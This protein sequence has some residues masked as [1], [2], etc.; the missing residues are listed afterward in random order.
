M[1]TQL[2]LLGMISL[3]SITTGN[4]SEPKKPNIILIYVDDLGYGDL[5][6]YG[7]QGIQTP[8]IDRLAKNGLL[9]T[10]AHCSA[11]TCTPSRYSLLTGSYAFRSNVRVLDGGEPA[12]IQPGMG[13]L[14]SMLQAAGYKTAIVGKWHLG[15][16]DGNTDWNRAI[17]PGP[18]EVGFDYS[19][20]I[21]TT[22]DR[23]PCVWVEN[24][25]IVNFDPEDPV[26]VNYRTR[27]GDDPA[28]ISDPELLRYGADTQ[29]NNTIVNGISRIGYMTGGKAAR[30]KD[31]KFPHVM[32]LKA[33]NFIKE[34]KDNP[35]FLYFSFH[36]I[37]VP[38]LPDYPFIG[39]SGMGL[40][41]DAIL[42]TD[43]T[44]GELI[45]SIEEYG[46]T[47]NTLVI[48][49]SDNGPVLDDGYD[50][51][52]VEL[53]GEHQPSGPFRGG[54]YSAFE[55]GTRVPTIVYWPGT[56]KPGKSDA[57][58]GQVDLYASLASLVGI[59]LNKD[60]APDSYNM[61][62]V[63][64]GKSQ[65]GREYL[66]EE[67][68]TLSLRYNKWKYIQ[69]LEGQIP[70]WIDVEKNIE[71]GLSNQPQ[72]YNL[73]NDIAET[74]N[75]A[76]KEKKLVRQLEKELERIILGKNKGK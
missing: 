27:V 25:H 7:A 30:W 71:S 33:R 45:K 23:V 72:L 54:K 39:K 57:L 74:R 59:K 58:A 6:C 49:T 2:S 41:G 67:S 44:T 20:I 3:A 64:L 52:A 12:L 53:L 19:F 37:H 47:E 11:A 63:W 5:G 26:R 13:T 24:H 62:D 56:V 31:E 55:A 17:K 1:K 38:R 40:R 35:F 76:D 34:N 60:D 14:P 61:I 51:L 43:W 73:E 68:L 22:G 36:D 29:H 18:L 65:N 46:L 70:D 8:H 21:P 50:D 69:P 75:L 9:M 16:G 28:G 10:D 15:L 66:L 4:P 42:Q 32:L 48:F